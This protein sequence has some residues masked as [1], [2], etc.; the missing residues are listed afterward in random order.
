MVIASDRA[1]FTSQAECEEDF[2]DL[3]FN[4]R[5][6]KNRT[7]PPIQAACNLS[8]PLLVGGGCLLYT[9]DPL[10]GCNLTQFKW[11]SIATP[12][13]TG[14]KIRLELVIDGMKEDQTMSAS[15]LSDWTGTMF[16]SFFP[17]N[18]LSLFY[19]SRIESFFLKRGL[20]YKGVF[21]FFMIYRNPDNIP[22]SDPDYNRNYEQTYS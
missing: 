5:F 14:S 6:Y 20:A 18:P 19:T 22:N 2:K 10:V 16:R 1:N 13:E 15:L 3:E 4:Y 8:K 12:D 17:S 21:D 7:S 9:S 11:D